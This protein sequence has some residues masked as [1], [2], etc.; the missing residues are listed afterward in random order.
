MWASGIKASGGFD[1]RVMLRLLADQ[2][3]TTGSWQKILF[4]DSDY[5]GLSEFDSDNNQILIADAGY[6]HMGFLATMQKVGIDKGYEARIAIGG[7]IAEGG[8]NGQGNDVFA[9]QKMGCSWSGYYAAAT[10][11]SLDVYHDYGADR[12]MYYTGYGGVRLW[13]DRYA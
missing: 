13:M 2:T 9:Y 10:T 4:D 7:A 11:V 6:Y 1:S 3:I 8:A 5:D 12:L